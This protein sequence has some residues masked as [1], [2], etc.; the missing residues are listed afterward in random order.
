MTKNDRDIESQIEKLVKF[1]TIAQLELERCAEEREGHE[2]EI[3]ELREVFH[4]LNTKLEVQIAKASA[5][6]TI[7]GIGGSIGISL[8]THFLTK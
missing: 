1:A 8:I 7:G 3:R 6:G 5:W 4:G 2:K